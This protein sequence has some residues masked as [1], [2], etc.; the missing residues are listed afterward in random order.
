VSPEE[1]VKTIKC[2]INVT[3]ANNLT[4]TICEQ[5]LIPPTTPPTID[6][7]GRLMQ[8]QYKIVVTAELS[9]V[10]KN[11]LLSKLK[12]GNTDMQSSLHVASLHLP[13]K[14]GTVP[15]ASMPI[16][17]EEFADDVDSQSQTSEGS[18]IVFGI[19]RAISRQSSV[20]VP[21]MDLKHIIARSDSI[22]SYS[23]MSS[24]RSWMSA[25]GGLSRNTS[26]TSTSSNFVPTFHDD[27]VPLYIMKELPS[28]T[29]ST[30]DTFG[31][32]A[33]VYE[34]Q[35]ILPNI[36]DM[37]LQPL[38]IG[39]HELSI[40]NS[41]R[42]SI[43]LS[44]ITSSP[45]SMPNPHKESWP[46]GESDGQPSRPPMPSPHRE[47]WSRGEPDGQPLRPPMPTMSFSHSSQTVTNS[48]RKKPFTTIF[49]DE[50][51]DDDDQASYYTQVSSA[52]TLVNNDGEASTFSENG[53]STN[54]S[55]TMVNNNMPQPPSDSRRPLANFI[56][57]QGASDSESSDVADDMSSE[58]SD[59]DDPVVILSRQRKAAARSN[60]KRFMTIHR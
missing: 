46:R 27:S 49:R 35:E 30:G 15:F 25:P 28:S 4:Q 3:S 53:M 11:S 51:S 6:S 39:M 58:D 17:P 26:S 24:S 7:N 18:T 45:V 14:L 43:V 5:I 23:S 54:T 31:S 29:P 40:N 59:A 56:P 36:P 33:P 20:S 1:P 42:N 60:Q 41:H 37:V 38:D 16:D 48:T 57:F 44:P 32:D 19:E 55:S 47:S 52:D 13:I 8:V 9:D 12:T 34:L 22:T 2:D 50:L 21:N 10:T